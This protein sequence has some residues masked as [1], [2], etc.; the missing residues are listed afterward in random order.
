MGQWGNAGQG[1]AGGALA[2]AAVGSIVP[3]LGT[4]IGALVGGGLGAL[5]GFFG[6]QGTNP[7]EDELRRLQQGYGNRAAPQMGPASQ[8]HNSFFR[9]NQ[10]QLVRMLEA[11]ASGRGP[12]LAAAQFE[13]ATDRNAR[14][15]QSLAAGTRGPNAAMAQ[16]QAMNNT[17]ALGQQAAQD[18]GAARIAEQ[19]M[20]MQ[21][22]G[23]TLHSARGADE[24]TSRFNASA[25]NE[26]M[27]ANLE[28]KLR[29]MGINDSAQLQAI[30][31]RLQGRG[32]SMGQQILA[33]G[34]GAFGMASGA[35]MFSRGGGGGGGAADPILDQMQGYGGSPDYTSNGTLINPWG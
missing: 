34:A 5:G 32:P 6:D 10:A 29:A 20:A 16:F 7:L 31:L 25:Q 22:L 17:A 19:Q 14:Q 24:Q 4:G 1:A 9:N 28:A 23:M 13:A 3:G 2:G 12:S 18:A 8:A 30:M 21:Q 33:G 11:Q 27:Q 15:Q 26:Q 35:G